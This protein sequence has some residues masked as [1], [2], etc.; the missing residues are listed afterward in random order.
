VT[1]TELITKHE[2]LRLTPYK[3][4]TGHLTIGVGRNLDAV[5]ISEEEAQILLDNDIDHATEELKAN[6]PAFS[7]L[8]AVREAALVDMCFNL[9]WGNLSTFHK[10]LAAISIGDWQAA[11]D[12]MLQS[13]WALQTGPRAIE[14]ARMMLTG[15]WPGEEGIA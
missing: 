4:S 12:D 6:F 8:D 5:G 14:D 10:T 3:D 7:Q 15:E 2:G 13:L 11:H 9:G 1:L